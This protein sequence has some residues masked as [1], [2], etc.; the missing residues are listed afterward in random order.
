MVS[1]FPPYSDVPPYNFMLQILNFDPRTISPNECEKCVA[2][3]ERA[4]TTDVKDRDGNA[5]MQ[6]RNVHDHASRIRW[7]ISK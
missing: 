3:S 4:K 5:R 2:A 7:P 6:S 1:R